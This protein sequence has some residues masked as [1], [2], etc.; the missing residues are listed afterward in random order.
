MYTLK[1]L[2]FAENIPKTERCTAAPD[3]SKVVKHFSH[4]QLCIKK[5]KP[6]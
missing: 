5:M 3:A 1:G 2:Q 4:D 6:V